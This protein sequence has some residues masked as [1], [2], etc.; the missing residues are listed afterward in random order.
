[1]KR[2]IVIVCAALAGLVRVE[3]E[4][5]MPYT[6]AYRATVTY[7]DNNPDLTGGYDSGE[8]AAYILGNVVNMMFHEIGHGIV[9]EFGIPIAGREEDAVDTLANITMIRTE[10]DPVLDTMIKSVADDYFAS[11]E[12]N[13]EQNGGFDASD[14]HSLD[15]QRAYNVICMLV[16]ADPDAFKESAD[17]AG[18]TPE[19]QEACQWEYESAVTSWDALLADYYRAE[20][21]NPGAPIPVTYGAVPAEMQSAAS[22]LKASRIAETVAQEA[23]RLVRFEPGV[24]VGVEKCDEENAY[25][26]S[27]ARKLTLCYELVSGYMNRAAGLN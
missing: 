15:S 8:V 20:G 7:L 11:G 16:G 23:N 2:V 21:E 3:A 18:M 4:S 25:W 14:E 22:L 12:F 19:R 13:D 26:D 5:S 1:M 17:N 6:D 24:T 9:S 10:A 27:S